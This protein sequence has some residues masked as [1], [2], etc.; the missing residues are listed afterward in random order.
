MVLN[1]VGVMEVNL[2]IGEQNLKYF[3]L[4]LKNVCLKKEIVFRKKTIIITMIHDVSDIDNGNSINNSNNNYD[5]YNNYYD[6][7]NNKRKKHP[8]MLITLF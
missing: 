4:F 8:L 1:D 6:N 5:N 3:S 2:V 7:N